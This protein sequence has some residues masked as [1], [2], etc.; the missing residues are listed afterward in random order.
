MEFNLTL[1]YP[2]RM[3]KIDL[4]YPLYTSV[5]MHELP[6]ENEKNWPLLPIVYNSIHACKTSIL[7]SCN[8]F[9]LMMADSCSCG[10]IFTFF[11]NN[12][13]SSKFQLS[14]C[15]KWAK[16]VSSS[17]S[18][19]ATAACILMYTMGSKGH[20]F[21]ILSGH[22]VHVYSGIQWIAKG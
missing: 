16:K 19:W 21:F 10:W 13:Q 6:R 17:N 12:Q 9:G 15:I 11:Q 2:E 7:I 3:K 20:F 22:F 8:M 18:L 14:I 4:F 1:C 5:Y